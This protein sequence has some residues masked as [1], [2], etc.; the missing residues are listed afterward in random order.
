M[1][2]MS[3][4]TKNRWGNF[5]FIT[6]Y[7][8]V[9]IFMI[10]LP[11]FWGIYLSFQK[12]DLFGP[13][14]FV[15][16][17]NYIRLFDNKIFIQTVWNTCY[18]VLLT[19]PALV[20]IGLGLAMALNQ[21]TRTANIL[22]GVFFASTILSV[23]VVTLIWRIIFIPNDGFMAMVFK[24]FNLEAIP[25]LSSPDWALKSIAIATIWWCLG[26]PMI[27]FTAALQ[28]IPKDLYEAA[29][30]DNAS[31]WTTFRK[32]TLPSITRTIILVTIIEIVMQF[33]LFGQALL[34]TNGGPNNTSRSIVM[35]IYDAG[36][37]RWDIGMAAAASQILFLIILV[38]AVAQFMISRKKG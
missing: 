37:R 22:R 10:A 29:Q 15:G 21:Q 38:A 5:L 36:F 7:L 2:L 26:L 27:L 19:V 3:P 17:N 20:V 23:T 14:K 31:K 24:W 11:L 18:F 4:A 12:V 1:S 9:F 25:F 35:F 8:L 28:Q 34:M 13:G 6:P 33:Q 30:L 16:W 32:I